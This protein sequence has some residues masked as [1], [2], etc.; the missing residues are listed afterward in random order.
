MK[1][2]LMSRAYLSLSIS[3]LAPPFLSF[4]YLLGEPEEREKEEEMT[5]ADHK[6]LEE[7]SAKEVTVISLMSASSSRPGPKGEKVRP[8]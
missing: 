2:T 6:L 1:Q 4:L 5:L 8:R 3:N 7:K